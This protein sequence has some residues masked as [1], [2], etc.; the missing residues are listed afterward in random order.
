MGG[1]RSV[2]IHAWSW[3]NYK[4]IYSNDLGMP[5]RKAFPES[6]AMWV[7]AEDEKRLAAYKLLAAYDQNQAAELAE[8]G[9]DLHA[10]DR[11]EFGDPSMFV[12]TLMSHVL[13]REQHITVPGA[14]DDTEG[15]PTPEAAAAARV[16]E[17]LEDWAEA[18]QL[19]MRMQQAERKA[20]TL[21]DGVYRL[22]WDPGKKRPT[23]RVSDPGF[24]F[25][26]IGEDDDGGEYPS[27]V[28]FAWELPEDPK[29]GL[30]ARLRRIT[31]ELDWIRPATAPG[32]DQSG[33]AV[34]APLPPPELE[35]GAAEAE[36][37]SPPLTPGD[38]LN[39]DTGAISR[40]YAWNDEPSYLTCYLTDA[41]WELGDIKGPVDVDSLPE[42]KA[43]FATRSDGEVLQRLDLLLDFIP[44]VHVPNT[45]PPAEEHWGQSS[46]AK[47]LQVFD[48]LAG[49]D[50]DSSRAS[51]T[52][53]SPI[54]GIS[55]VQAGGRDG[56]Q[57]DV[58]PG[59][60]WNLGENGH[61]T[62]IDTA[63]QLAGLREHVH[64]LKDRAANVARLPAVALG[65]L[66]PS[67]VPS[68]Y[69]LQL[70][71]G[72]LDSL[73]G[74]MRLARDHKYALL[75][76]FVQRLYLAG[77]HPDWAG[78]TVQPARIT[79][80]PYTPTDKQ[81]VLEQ[82][83]AGV[84]KVFS[85]ET[86]VRMLAEAGFPIDDVAAEIERIESRQFEQAKAL[87]DATG[88]VKAVGDFLGIDI[89]EPDTP[90]A[91]QLPPAPGQQP[92]NEGDDTDPTSEN[93][94]PGQT[95]GNTE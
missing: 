45:V 9:G 52:T 67:K 61:L 28:H 64:D 13:G 1:L 32:V 40:M 3:L 85:R 81:S 20:V 60:A 34:R 88:D 21:G 93:T 75:L 79:W 37:P 68:G 39:P 87:A 77:Q 78:V 48:E 46:L 19:P 53:G 72:P 56:A 44:V 89:D 70:S 6:V 84:D 54:I 30:K 69:A 74:G 11:R 22:A 59:T 50:T 63:P 95:G 43:T 73:I 24:Y 12:D 55:G 14:E 16:Q 91:P 94:P 33:R 2:I 58:A 86:A 41:T 5:N 65:T 31:Y 49:A 36:L 10:R 51:A 27:R 82:V 23:L 4:P 62:S 47:V 76:R 29:R 38:T 8:V 80:G 71:L 26:V 7:P 90:P 15:E 42:A 35:D 92:E 25:P 18:E 66:D 17:L 83:T 57:M